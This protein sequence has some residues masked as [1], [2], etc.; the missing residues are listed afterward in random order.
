VK[1]LDQ[2]AGASHAMPQF[3]ERRVA[4]PTNFAAL[5]DVARQA[6]AQGGAGRP[7]VGGNALARAAAGRAGTN[8]QVARLTGLAAADPSTI[9]ERRPLPSRQP[10]RSELLRQDL[11]DAAGISPVDTADAGKWADLINQA[12]NKHGVDPTLVAA[13]TK[14][15]SGFNPRAVSRA[16]AKGMMQLM[17]G[18][19]KVLGVTDS[20][21][22]AQNVDGGTRYIGE[23]LKRFGKPEL[24][25][26]AYN[27]GP[28][29][30]AKHGGIPPFKETQTYVRKVLDYQQRMKGAS[31]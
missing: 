17:D 9:G 26:A 28:G 25:L 27:A 2:V 20:F 8:G 13:I 14:A 6:G 21:D 22:P 11:A 5:L 15:E 7:P 1:Q 23:M 3:R 29:A 4:P 18:T 10:T 16:G 31:A 24:A 12:A 19:A 30:V